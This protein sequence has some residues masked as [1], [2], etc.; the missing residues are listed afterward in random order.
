MEI[1][2]LILSGAVEV[3]GI[4]PET[5]EMLYNFTDKLKDVSPILHREVNNMFNAHVTRLWELDMIDMDIT[6]EN[7]IVR[8]TKKAFNPELLSQLDEEERYTLKE[9]RRNLIRE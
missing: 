7:P 1:E 8:L 3:A 9:I 5:G 4:D 6:A 2:D